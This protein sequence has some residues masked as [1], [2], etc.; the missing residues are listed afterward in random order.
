[1]SRA[2]GVLGIT[3]GCLGVVQV[4]LG[5]TFWTGNA[6]SLIPVHMALGTALVLCLWALA[7]LGAAARIPV[8]LVLAG[9]GW[10]ALTVIY[11]MTQE[12][13]LA[14]ALHW[15]AQV[16]H[17]TVGVV[18]VLLAALIARSIQGRNLNAAII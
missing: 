2:A 5:V 17:L 15:I 10:G 14:G 3:A 16:L 12:L 11:G 4:I 6:D 13:V 18:A 8:V 1:M 7:G 9:F